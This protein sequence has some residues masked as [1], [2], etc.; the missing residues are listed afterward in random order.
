MALANLGIGRLCMVRGG[1][2]AVKLEYEESIASFTNK[3]AEYYR[4]QCERY[5]K[6]AQQ[7]MMRKK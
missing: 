2:E 7:L 1:I 3:N 4:T 5:I 6:K